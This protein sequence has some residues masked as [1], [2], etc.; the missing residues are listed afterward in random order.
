[1]LKGL[2][3][4]DYKK[5]SCKGN[6]MGNGFTKTQYGIMQRKENELKNSFIEPYHFPTLVSLK[7]KFNGKFD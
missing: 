1:M 2:D 5:H 6:A 3:V 7:M 4:F